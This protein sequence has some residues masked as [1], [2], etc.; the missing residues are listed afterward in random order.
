[1]SEEALHMLSVHVVQLLLPSVALD[2]AH[3][4]LGLE[5]HPAWDSVGYLQEGHRAAANRCMR[6]LGKLARGH[7]HA[8]S[9]RAWKHGAA[10]NTR[11]NIALKA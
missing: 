1:M 11:Q 9:A 2:P 5:P 3:L 6:W 10:I 4:G 7:S 8:S